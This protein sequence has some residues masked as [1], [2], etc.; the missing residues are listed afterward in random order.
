P[1]P[2]L[3]LLLVTP[4]LCMAAESASAAKPTTRPT[5][6]IAAIQPRARLVDWKMKNPDDVLT[7]LDQSLT[8]LEGLLDQAAERKCDAAA[9]PEDTLGLG[10]W[11]AG[12]EALVRDLL[13]RAV[14]KMLT[15]LGADVKKHNM[16]LVCCNDHA[17]VD[18]KIYNTS[19][20]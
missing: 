2:A 12:N 6:R 3:L 7:Q 1:M 16:Y 14:T 18:G 11:E 9:L 13:P 5:V 10:N 17:E 4:A 15:R 19:F 8:E 20:F